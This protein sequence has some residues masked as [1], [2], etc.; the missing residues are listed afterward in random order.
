MQIQKR[1]EVGLW[2]GYE[3]DEEEEEEEEVEEEEKEEGDH[4][5]SQNQLYNKVSP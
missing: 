3:T 1:K 5:T 2:T 4:Y